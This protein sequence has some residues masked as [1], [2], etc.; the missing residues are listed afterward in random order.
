M[1]ATRPFIG[2]PGLELASCS[3]VSITNSKRSIFSDFPSICHLQC[4]AAG[5]AVMGESM[6]AERM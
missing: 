4:L 2:I 6:Q 5:T 3:G 1:V